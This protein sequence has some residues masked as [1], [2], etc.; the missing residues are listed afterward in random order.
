VEGSGRGQIHVPS[1]RSG[2]KTE[3]DHEN[4][5]HNSQ[6]LDRDFNLV[7]LD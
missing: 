3:E 5:G 1:L 7:R 2:G 6:F 4:F